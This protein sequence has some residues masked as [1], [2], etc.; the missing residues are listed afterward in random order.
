MNKTTQILF[1]VNVGKNLNK[2]IKNG[3]KR[4]SVIEIPVE[5]DENSYSK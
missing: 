4:K 2:K 1:A 3:I 5:K